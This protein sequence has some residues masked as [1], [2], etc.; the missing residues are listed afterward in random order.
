MIADILTGGAAG[1]I[2][3]VIG[4][5][6]NAVSA[7]HQRKHERKL[8]D[9][10]TKRID[11]KAKN[12]REEM[13]MEIAHAADMQKMSAVTKLVEDDNK[14]LRASFAHDTSLNEDSTWM[15][16]FRKSVRPVITYSSVYYIMLMGIF[17]SVIYYINPVANVES[18]GFIKEATQFTSFVGHMTVS[19]WFA[20]RKVSGHLLAKTMT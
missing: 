1:A 14:N 6:A 4:G 16:T 8:Y 18:L 9:K 13:A 3:G 19:W 20:A 10:Q 15:G 11:V 7:H 12:R 17:H 5:I 2:T